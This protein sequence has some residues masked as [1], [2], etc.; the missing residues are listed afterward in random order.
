MESGMS[1]MM[2]FGSNN[3]CYSDFA[4]LLIKESIQMESN[5][6]SGNTFIIIMKCNY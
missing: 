3:F 2:I 1:C 5:N 6:I 4:K